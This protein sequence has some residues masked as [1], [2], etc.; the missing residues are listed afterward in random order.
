MPRTAKF[1]ADGLEFSRARKLQFGVADRSRQDLNRVIRA[2]ESERVYRVSACDAK[3]NR[4]SGRNQDAVRDE[5][6]LLCDH[7]DGNRAIGIL[8][9]SKIVFYK[10]SGEVER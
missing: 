7:A 10:L 8:L 6:V 9:S 1:P 3:M 4:N 5:Q 2:V